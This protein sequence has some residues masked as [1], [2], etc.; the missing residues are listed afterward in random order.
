M[1][2]ATFFFP[3]SSRA[4][5]RATFGRKIKLVLSALALKIYVAEASMVVPKLYASV[6]TASEL[7]ISRAALGEHMRR[8]Y[9]FRRRKMDQALAPPLAP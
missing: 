6:S 9:S 4:L 3:R 8:L 1:R 2:E 7:Q 5:S